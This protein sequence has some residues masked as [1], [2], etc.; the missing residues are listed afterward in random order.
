VDQSTVTAAQLAALLN[1]AESRI[2]NVSTTAITARRLRQRSAT[3]GHAMARPD[4]DS[5]YPDDPQV[6]NGGDDGI[7]ANDDALSVT[8]G[9]EYVDDDDYH[10]G[11]VIVDLLQYDDANDVGDDYSDGYL[12][13]SEAIGAGDDD[14]YYYDESAVTAA[15]DDGDDY[16]DDVHEHEY[17]RRMARHLAG[18][19]D[20]SCTC[21]GV[22]AVVLGVVD[23]QPLCVW[24]VERTSV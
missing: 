21:Q 19:C 16:D 13:D 24:L 17:S 22:H 7:D 20:G 1:I 8:V 4:A 12:T 15:A 3:I 6:V 23:V 18:V 2:T 9:M 11:D 14:Y 5:Y 10:I